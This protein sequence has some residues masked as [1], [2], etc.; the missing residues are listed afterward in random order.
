MIA[1]CARV[2]QTALPVCALAAPARHCLAQVVSVGE[3]S[4]LAAGASATRAGAPFALCASL[5]MYGMQAMSV[6]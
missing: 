4:G 3:L 2:Q 5:A 6:L 1:D